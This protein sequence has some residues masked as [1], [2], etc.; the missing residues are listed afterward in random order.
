MDPSNVRI[1]ESGLGQ[2]GQLFVRPTPALRRL[3][4]PEDMSR[5]ECCSSRRVDIV[6]AASIW[7]VDDKHSKWYHFLAG[8]G[9]IDFGSQVVDASY[10]H[11]ST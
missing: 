6:R 1:D 5:I 4:D 9:G 7:R 3:V 2:F 8:L 11:H 10:N